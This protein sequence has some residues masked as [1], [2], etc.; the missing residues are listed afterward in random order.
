[1][2]HGGVGRA[3]PLNSPYDATS[4]INVPIVVAKDR[5]FVQPI[6]ENRATKIPKGGKMYIMN[7]RKKNVQNITVYFIL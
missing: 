2:N 6:I 5:I 4:N 7:Q 1:M 3:S